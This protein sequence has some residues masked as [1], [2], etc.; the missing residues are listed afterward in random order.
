MFIVNVLYIVIVIVIG[1][2]EGYVILF[3]NVL[4]VQLFILCELGG[5][6]G[7]GINL[8]QLFV[9]GYLVC[10]LGVLKY[11]VGQ[12]KVVLLVEI[13]I[14][15]KVGIGQ[16]LIGFGI[17]VVLEIL[18]LGLLCEQVEELV[19]KVYIVCLYFNVICGN[20]DVML[21]VV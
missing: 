9:V 15:G 18:V 1:G 14:I 16:I 5:V 6:G 2:C 4:D 12:V 11:V 20:I 19:Q 3:D 10:F 13:V 7:L 17:E 8:E 21:M